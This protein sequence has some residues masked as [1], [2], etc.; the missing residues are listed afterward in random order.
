MHVGYN[1]PIVW[2]YPRCLDFLFLADDSY[3]NVTRKVKHAI[4]DFRDLVPVAPHGSVYFRHIRIQP[5]PFLT[6]SRTYK[7]IVVVLQW[8]T[9][10]SGKSKNLMHASPPVLLHREGAF[11]NKPVSLHILNDLSSSLRLPLQVEEFLRIWH[12]HTFHFRIVFVG[13]IV[14]AADVSA[15]HS[16]RFRPFAVEACAVLP[17]LKRYGVAQIVASG[18]FK[19]FH[20]PIVECAPKVITLHRSHFADVAQCSES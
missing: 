6:A 15:L 20:Q 1:T 3:I 12:L 14:D 4:A 2:S 9:F 17:R 16:P 7:H 18:I 8:R 13:R 5:R 10:R 11:H 19:T